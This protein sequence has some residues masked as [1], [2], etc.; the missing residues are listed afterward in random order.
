[1]NDARDETHGSIHERRKRDGVLFKNRYFKILSE[2]QP[3]NF[4]KAI[5]K[6]I[7]DK[8]LLKLLDMIIDSFP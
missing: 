8:D 7:Q 3:Q 1:M 5:E 2:R 6:K 4:E